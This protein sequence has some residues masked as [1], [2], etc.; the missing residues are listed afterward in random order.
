MECILACKWKHMKRRG[1]HFSTVQSVLGMC[2][3]YENLKV[4]KLPYKHNLQQLA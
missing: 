1:L 2:Y 3:N 4:D